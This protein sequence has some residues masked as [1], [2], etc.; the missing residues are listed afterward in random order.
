M[1]V[2][3]C[4]H[5]K[6]S[7]LN[8][9]YAGIGWRMLHDVVP[10]DPIQ[11]HEGRKVVN[12]ASLEICFLQYACN[13]KADGD[14]WYCTPRQRQH[15]SGQIFH[16]HHSLVS[17]DCQ[18]SAIFESSND[19]ISGS[20]VLIDLVFHSRV[21]FSGMEDFQS[22]LFPVAANHT[23]L[24]AIVCKISNGRISGTSCPINFMF[25]ARVGF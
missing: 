17:H 18:I 15:F 24:L 22:G 11:G 19:D 5:K 23:W 4:V 2:H 14:L 6:F 25:G 16:I 13:Q 8:K 21:Q 3:L 9:I 12:R 10:Y 20:D 7:D 1:S